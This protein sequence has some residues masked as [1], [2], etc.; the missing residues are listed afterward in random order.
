METRRT[1]LGVLVA[2]VTTLAGCTG[3]DQQPNRTQSESAAGS[4]TD[5]VETAQQTLT[6]REIHDN[7]IYGED[8]AQPEKAVVPL[9]VIHVILSA[10][11][12]DF[13]FSNRGLINK[14]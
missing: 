1:V 13:Y 3:N 4:Q 8:N 2:G 10:I 12:I 6:G 7:W 11:R 9:F 5:A 14:S